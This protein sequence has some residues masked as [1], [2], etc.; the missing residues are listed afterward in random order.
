MSFQVRDL[1][2]TEHEQQLKKSKQ[3]GP[4]SSLSKDAVVVD[5]VVSTIG[6][7]LVGGPAGTMEG[8]R[9]ADVAKAI[10]SAKNIP[11]VV[12]APLLIQ[13]CARA[14][15]L[16]PPA[17][18]VIPLVGTRCTVDAEKCVLAC[19]ALCDH[20]CGGVLADVL[21]EEDACAGV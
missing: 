6:F 17:H 10:L 12:A 1:L 8:G 20:E 9:Q 16:T 7:P 2:T 4:A 14:M 13:V 5:A 11:Y 3:S 21:S 18:S 15:V 19:T